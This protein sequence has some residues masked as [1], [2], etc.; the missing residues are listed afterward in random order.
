MYSTLLGIICPFM[1]INSKEQCF[2][3][4]KIN[5]EIGAGKSSSKKPTPINDT[6]EADYTK[7]SPWGEGGL[8]SNS[9]EVNL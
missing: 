1:F 7:P 3:E 4:N 6:F 9:D 8:R 5:K 2:L